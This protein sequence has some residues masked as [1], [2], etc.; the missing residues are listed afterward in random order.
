MASSRTPVP[1]TL[2]NPA[3]F[4]VRLA[5]G[6]I[7]AAHGWQ[8]L[9]L[10]GLEATTA[11][12]EGMGIPLPQVSAPVVALAELLGG[13]L[14]ILGL[15]TTVVGLLLAVEMAVAAVVVHLPG[16]LFIAD[17]GW[18]LVAALGAGA[19]A[20]AVVGPGSIALDP[21]LR[22]KGRRGRGWKRPKSSS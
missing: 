10:D 22:G 17:G 6:V 2:R 5:L 3:L 7:F 12:F 16:G 4:V 19:L 18:E 20:L 11:G 1:A 8:K 9:A 13:G 14:L 15:F 21:V